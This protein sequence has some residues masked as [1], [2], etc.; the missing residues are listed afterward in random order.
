M[1]APLGPSLG[2]VPL[3]K[4]E[5]EASSIKPWTYI[6]NHTGHCPINFCLW[7]CCAV[8]CLKAT[9]PN[10]ALETLDHRQHHAHHTDSKW[11]VCPAGYLPFESQALTNVNLR[12]TTPHSAAAGLAATSEAAITACGGDKQLLRR[13]IPTH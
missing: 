2:C 4:Q 10:L 5:H 11:M 3:M 7:N 12:S 6:R 13:H 1:E 8:L 9:L